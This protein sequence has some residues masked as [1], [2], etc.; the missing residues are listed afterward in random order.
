M[1]DAQLLKS[2]AGGDRRAFEELYRC[3]YRRILKFV[4]RLIP[5]CNSADEIINDTFMI[6]WQ[7]ASQFR[8][9]SQVSTWIFGIA[10]RIALKSLRRHRR[11]QAACVDTLPESLV[12]PH[13]EAEERDWLD[14]GLRRLSDKQRLTL[15]LTYRLGHSIQRVALMTECPVGT[16]KARLFHARGQLRRQLIALQ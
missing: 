6:V 11:W 10:Y 3:Y 2:I 13:G 7:R 8:D 15:L 12:D 1:S 4:E 16:V 5:L 14:E 9:R